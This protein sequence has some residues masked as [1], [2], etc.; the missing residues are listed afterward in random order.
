MQFKAVLDE[1]NDNEAFMVTDFSA[2]AY[3][4]ECPDAQ[5]CRV[6]NFTNDG[7]RLLQASWSPS[8]TRRQGDKMYCNSDWLGDSAFA[9]S[10]DPMR[11][12]GVTHQ[13]C[14]QR[15]TNET[16]CKAYSYDVSRAWCI[17][18][19]ADT[20]TFLIHVNWVSYWK[21]QS[22]LAS[23]V[24][25]PNPNPILRPDPNA[26]HSSVAVAYTE[27]IA[28]A[29]ARADTYANAAAHSHTDGAPDAR[30]DVSADASAHAH[31]HAASD[32]VAECLTHASANASTEPR[33]D[34]CTDTAA[35]LIT[36]ACADT[37]P[38]SPRRCW[39]RIVV[40]QADGPADSCA[41]CGANKGS[42][43]KPNAR[44]HAK[45]HT[46]AHTFDV[47]QGAN[48]LRGDGDGVPPQR[49]LAEP[50]SPSTAF[51]ASRGV[52]VQF[53]VHCG[54]TAGA[55]RTQQQLTTMLADKPPASSLVAL[56]R[57]HMLDAG[58]DP[59]GAMVAAPG[60][61]VRVGQTMCGPGF[62]F[63]WAGSK[64][65]GVCVRCPA[66]TFK[67]FDGS[68]DAR[69]T[70]CAA[71]QYN[72][73]NGSVA[74][75]ACA[76]GK[77]NPMLG[78][79][80]ES[81]GTG[82]PEC[83]ACGTLG[84][85]VAESAF[86]GT[87]NVDGERTACTPDVAATAGLTA[88]FIAL[89]LL[90]I[91]F[92][93]YGPRDCGSMSWAKRRM[94]LGASGDFISDGFYIATAVYDSPGLKVAACVQFVTPTLAFMVYRRRLVWQH[95]GNLHKKYQLETGGPWEPSLSH[96]LWKVFKKV[97]WLAAL[98]IWYPIAM[99]L[100]IN[101]KLFAFKSFA[102][103]QY[104]ETDET[105]RTSRTNKFKGSYIQGS[106]QASKRESMEGSRRR[107]TLSHNQY[108][109]SDRFKLREQKRLNKS[110]NLTLIFELFM[111]TLP[112]V[113]I[114]VYNWYM[115]GAS[116]HDEVFLISMGFAL[117]A[118]AEGAFPLLFWILRLGWASGITVELF[119]DWECTR[120][121]MKN[122]AQ[123][124]TI[125]NTDSDV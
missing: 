75:L 81:G 111:A 5:V 122:A 56:M 72:P 62:F 105:N 60:D 14:K 26:N 96:F 64:V 86:I 109:G 112:S 106:T 84:A 108:L 103:D 49:Q 9:D 118:T 67:S 92:A 110:F 12:S 91:F 22:P 97:V 63:Q 98:V 101:C 116:L 34:T 39:I 66:G 31:T 83:E 79:A 119:D 2:E 48:A 90:I 32:S 6:T 33:A 43:T 102:D 78:V 25:G 21:P 74:C 99:V 120:C 68:A 51:D 52:D 15:C 55:L 20:P 114:T 80:A 58:V 1:N 85:A 104:E 38:N 27:P 45:S 88:C 28:S 44:P 7:L 50:L 70:S 57:Q 54:D 82:S 42:H 37:Q 69:C 95:L 61:P 94:I 47:R 35:E 10:A 77:S 89:G 117:W 3:A 113:G 71:G 41:D 53:E 46:V 100:A 16:S 40:M 76:S 93:R 8:Y 115:T 73:V 19:T 59:P 4:K 65:P 36:N 24:S 11:L 13:E 123:A 23:S 17:L 107:R 121:N 30:T 125:A 29:N 124:V 18:C 87:G